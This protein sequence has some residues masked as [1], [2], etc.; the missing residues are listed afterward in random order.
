[1]S[2]SLQALFL[3]AVAGACAGAFAALLGAFQPVQL[4]VV[5]VAAHPDWPTVP[6]VHTMDG[7]RASGAVVADGWLLTCSHALP[8]TGLDLDMAIV[9]EVHD[10]PTLDL[11]LVRVEGLV[12]SHPIAGELPGLG[13]QLFVLS[14]QDGDTL[15]VTEGRQA[16]D[17]NGM[18]CPVIPGSS[19][20]P[21]MNADGEI[22]G[23]VEQV[24]YMGTLDA[25]YNNQRTPFL[26]VIPHVAWYT[27]IDAEAREWIA[28]I[29]D[30]Q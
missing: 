26:Q 11:A 4:E 22:V 5:E 14:W 18:S 16:A 20:G 23:V 30:P 12:G 7:G 3:A 28:S 15:M 9:Q 19:G 25:R 21:V 1:M 24:W 8:V 13:D 29:I 6:L 17:Q 10:H 27:P 2:K